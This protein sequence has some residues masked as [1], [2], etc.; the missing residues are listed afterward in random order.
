MQSYIKLED[1]EAFIFALIN[2]KTKDMKDY[3][4]S[5]SDSDKEKYKSDFMKSN[6][7]IYKI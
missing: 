4:N 2:Q 3:I 7:I 5:I 1:A 6:F